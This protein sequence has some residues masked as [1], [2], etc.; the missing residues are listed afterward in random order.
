MTGCPFV[1]GAA[2]IDGR[3]FRAIEA[4]GKNVFAWFTAADG[5]PDVVVRKRDPLRSI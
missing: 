4:I 2:L 1:Q 5:G 3:V